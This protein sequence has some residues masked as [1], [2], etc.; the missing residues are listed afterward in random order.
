MEN[1]PGIL[2][3]YSTQDSA[4]FRLSW[5]VLQISVTVPVG[6]DCSFKRSM[7]KVCF[8]DFAFWVLLV[9]VFGYGFFVD[10]EFKGL[11]GYRF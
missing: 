9:L 2:N 11:F 8:A 10:H 4:N 3:L 6:S 7:F 5:F 1:W